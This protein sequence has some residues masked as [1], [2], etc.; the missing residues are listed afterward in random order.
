MGRNLRST[1]GRMLLESVQQAGA[2]ELFGIPGDFVLPLFKVIESWNGLPLYTLSHE[3]GVGFAAD[4]AAR[5]AC[6]PSVAVVTYGAGALNMINP[7][8]ASYAEQVPVVVVSGGPGVGE[9]GSQL[10]L[11]HQAKR[12]GS[13][14]RMFQEVTCAQTRLSDPATAPA[15]VARVL[16]ACVAQSRPV[17]IEVPRDL[18]NAAC[19]GPMPLPPRPAADPAALQACLDEV[20]QELQSAKDP[21]LMVGV[22]I[23]RMGL[24]SRVARL[25]RL[26]DI[27]VVTSFMGRGLLADQKLKLRGTYLGVAGDDEVTDLVEHSDVPLLL[28]VIMSDTNLGISR[29][30]LNIKSCIVAGSG[31]VSLGYHVYPDIPLTDFVDGLLAKLDTVIS[32]DEPT[33][34]ARHDEPGSQVLH[35][36]LDRPVTSDD[37]AEVLNYYASNS[38]PFQLVADVGDSLFV[39]MDVHG[40]PLAAPGYYASMGFAVPAALGVQAAT[41]RRPVILVGDGA[42]EMTGWELGH[43]PRHGWDPIVIVLNN[44]GWEMLRAF[45]PEARFNNLC[46]WRFGDLANDLGGHG[47]RVH[48][49]DQLVDE[50]GRALAQRG[51]F[52]LIDVMLPRGSMSRRMQKFVNGISRR[53]SAPAHTSAVPV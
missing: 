30:R 22:E 18:V 43:C 11:H 52:Q 21:V 32:I 42:F 16:G 38:E 23:R 9:Q 28:G 44:S 3:P 6:R 20:L 51:K 41:G 48:T 39:A 33:R 50:V 1:I 49:H 46:R 19:D 14:Y 12:L 26:L 35:E 29:K 45:E 10:L 2:R 31:Q 27:P 24:E 5:S 34:A 7:V 17:Y 25:A 37:V 47:V 8:A 4:G 36:R 15:E 13:Q 53:G 40:V